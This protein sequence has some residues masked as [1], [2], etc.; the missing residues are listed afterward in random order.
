MGAALPGR[1]VERGGLIAGFLSRPA[2]WLAGC[3]RERSATVSR[4]GWEAPPPLLPLPPQLLA[5]QGRYASAGS[6]KIFS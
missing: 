4:T 5:V 1:S 3:S 6:Y 2:G